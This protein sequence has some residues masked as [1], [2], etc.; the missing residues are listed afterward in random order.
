MNVNAAREETRTD[1]TVVDLAAYGARFVENP[2]PVYA[3]LRAKGPVHRVRLPGQERDWWLVVRNE[4]G[5]LLLAD[6]RFSKDWRSSGVWPADALPINENMIES[7]PPKHTR[8]RALVTREFTSRRIE[9][10]APRV[11]ELTADLLDSMTAGPDARADLVA[12]LSFPLSMSVICELLG[13]PDLD[14]QSFKVWSNEIVASTSPEATV[15]AVQAVTAYLTGLI[16]QKRAE[17]GD[18]LL[19]AL[20]RTT[21][22]EG[23]RLSPDELVGMAFLLLAAGHETTVG[24]ISNTVLALLRHP[25]QLALL[26]SDYSLAGNAVEETLRYD[27][28][29]ENSTY[30]FA[31]E[32]MDFCG[33][34]FEKGDPVLVSLASAGRDA[35]R[36]E[37]ADRF[38]ITRTARGHLTFG[39]GIHYCLGAPLARLEARVA[40]RALLER[41][42]ELRLDTSEPLVYLPGMLVRGVRRLPVRWTA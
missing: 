23:D 30:R 39:H 26:R 29:V 4:E 13:V 42:P 16:E 21:D 15:A 20:L 17:P 34:R 27:S 25:D 8:L 2:Y 1:E 18:D 10:L 19:S 9:A 22:E 40:V 11:H 14:R 36:F 33:A 12:A 3:E 38:D 5:R 24:L 35:E 41:C 6:A 31:T 32:D 28:P 7:D 37:D